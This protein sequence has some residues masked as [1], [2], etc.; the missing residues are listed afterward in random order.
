[1]AYSNSEHVFL[2]EQVHQEK[3][4]NFGTESPEI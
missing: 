2:Q 1:M 4:K 3:S